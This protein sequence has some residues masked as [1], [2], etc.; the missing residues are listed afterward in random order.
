MKTKLIV[1]AIITCLTQTLP[2]TGQS[3][4][5]VNT[6]P[7][8]WLQKIHA[9]GLDTVFIVG[10]NGLIA[11]STDRTRNWNKQYY[12]TGVTLND[13][14]FVNHYI[15][16]A[17]GANG[18][19]LK[20][21][22]AGTNWS[23]ITSGTINNLNAIAATSLDNIWI[24]G[25]S[26]LAIYSTDSGNTWTIKDF[27]TTSGLN[28]I[29]FQNG[30]GYIVG[31]NKFSMKTLDSGKTWTENLINLPGSIPSSNNNLISVVQTS[32]HVYTLLGASY[33]GHYMKIDNNFYPFA[34]SEYYSSFNMQN[35]SIG[36]CLF[37][38][39]TTNGDRI[40]KVYKMKNGSYVEEARLYP[41][42]GQ[43]D[44][45]H[46]DIKLINDTI[47]YLVSGS[48]LYQRVKD[49]V[50]GID[51]TQIS[52]CIL[53]NEISNVLSI[54]SFSK[55][56]E[57][58]EIYNISGSR[59]CDLH[60]LNGMAQQISTTNFGKGTYIVRTIFSDKSKN[61]TKWIKS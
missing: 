41:T 61:I 32:N 4:V 12:S 43:L 37:T 28:D 42:S 14:V 25:D 44:N 11:K 54:K 58:I 47:G 9:H 23:Q 30:L 45:T 51:E 24:I 34:S 7:N 1:I 57:D 19:I 33:M 48:V 18:T 59:I 21:T 16:F 53:L 17:V 55:M 40:I 36:C 49:A 26:G 38:S 46:S 60:G 27:T 13:I 39:I 2:V 15:G 31:A 6:L 52:P 3:W 10:K 35:D 56:I 22:D 50:D 8:E 5:A 20:T 29:S